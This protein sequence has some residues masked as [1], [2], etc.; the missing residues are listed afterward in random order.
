MKKNTITACPCGSKK[1]FTQCCERIINGT[2]F[3]ATPEALMRSRYTAY[4]LHN[5]QYLNESW[6]P[7]TRPESIDMDTSIQWLRLKIISTDTDHVEFI[8]T[9]RVNGKAFRL[10]ENSHF[11]FEDER[12]LY[13][14][15][16]ILSEQT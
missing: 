4:T 2:Q 10:H 6:H 5:A 8:A 3:A 12:W 7:S 1:P 14:E 15:G 11:K 13:V 16:E 9:Y